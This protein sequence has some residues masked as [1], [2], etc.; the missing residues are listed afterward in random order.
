MTHT[1]A[2]LHTRCHRCGHPLRTIKSIAAGYGPTCA[3]R[4]RRATEML[5]GYSAAQRAAVREVIA[6]GGILPLRSTIFLAVS[7]DGTAIHRTDARGYCTCPAGLKSRP[8]Y[9]TAA[10]RSLLAA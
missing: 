5:A 10:A 8:C 3:R 4:I 2:Q 9:H 6:D 7:A 1:T